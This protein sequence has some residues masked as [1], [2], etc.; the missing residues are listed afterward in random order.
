[1]SILVPFSIFI[2]DL[3]DGTEYILSKCGGN[4]QDGSSKNF[5]GMDFYL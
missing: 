3:E 1:M 5:G 4:K 2:N